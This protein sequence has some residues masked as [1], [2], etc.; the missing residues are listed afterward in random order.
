MTTSAC[1]KS[2]LDD[3][4]KSFLALFPQRFDST[5]KRVGSKIWRGGSQWHHLS[6]F[7]IVETLSEATT[8]YRGVSRGDLTKFAILTF[9][10]SESSEADF[11]INQ[12]DLLIKDSSLSYCRYVFDN[13][14][15]FYFYFSE[16]VKTS[17]VDS[18]L[19]E[20]LTSLKVDKAVI[21]V[22]GFN[23]NIPIP[24]QCGFSWCNS[25]GEVTKSRDA[26]KLEDAVLLFLSNIEHHSVT[27]HT[28]SQAFGAVKLWHSEA[29]EFA[30]VTAKE[31]TAIKGNTDLELVIELST[32]KPAQV[33][34]LNH[35]AQ[36]ATNYEI[37]PSLPGPK[38]KKL[39]RQSR[40]GSKSAMQS[41]PSDRQSGVP[42]MSQ[43]I[44][45]FSMPTLDYRAPPPV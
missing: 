41:K 10:N 29:L 15:Y 39:S 22:P 45:P 5:T 37:L 44:L 14:T 31:P 24:L 12:L 20:W 26:L 8:V 9:S 33:T 3:P 38:I 7:E 35:K 23:E 43:L 27:F 13:N 36:D 4:I 30:P 11:L 34:R 17:S 42:S 2:S 1:S 18:I 25:S 28:F 6:D 16:W 21:S 19:F 40:Q 32:E